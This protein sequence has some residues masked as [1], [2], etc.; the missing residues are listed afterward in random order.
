MAKPNLT[1]TF[2]WHNN[3]PIL[4][5]VQTDRQTD[6]TNTDNLS[7]THITKNSTNKNATHKKC[8]VHANIWYSPKR[9]FGHFRKFWKF[10]CWVSQLAHV[11]LAFAGGG[12][13]QHEWKNQK[14]LKWPEYQYFPKISKKFEHFEAKKSTKKQLVKKSTKKHMCFL[15]A[16]RTST[17]NVSKHAPK[18]IGERQLEER[19][20]EILAGCPLLQ[21]ACLY[22]RCEFQW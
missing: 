13:N 11:K 2:Q 15:K 16:L 5:C 9:F 20:H 8:V 17:A 10:L 4:R 14:C 22:S 19:N 7:H 12:G 6:K 1:S 3:T 18:R 21:C